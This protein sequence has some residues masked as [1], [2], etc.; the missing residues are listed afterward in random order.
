MLDLTADDRDSEY[1]AHALQV[2]EATALRN[3]SKF[4]KLYAAAPGHAQYVMDT[5]VDRER[6]SGLRIFCKAYQV[7]DVAFVGL[8]LGFD[9]D[10]DG[11]DGDDDDDRQLAKQEERGRK[12]E[13]KCAWW[14]EDHGATVSIDG[15]TLDCKLSRPN[16]V[17]H[18]ISA[19]RIEDEKER[20]RKAEIVPITGWP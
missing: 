1:I 14:L 8:Q 4:F 5:F 16:L 13:A 6:L 2:R 11:D 19:K 15:A 7:I 9:D 10:G 3:Y 12:A 20:K 17:E 18:S